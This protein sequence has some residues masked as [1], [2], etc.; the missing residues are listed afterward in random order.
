VE[1]FETPEV[2]ARR[3]RQQVTEERNKAYRNTVTAKAQV[4]SMRKKIAELEQD[5][6]FRRERAAALARSGATEQAQA[7]MAQALLLERQVATLRN[8]L[9]QL[10][11][12]VEELQGALTTLEVQRQAVELQAAHTVARAHTAEAIKA[13]SAA[14]YGDPDSPGESAAELLQRANDRSTMQVALSQA[15]LEVGAALH[16]DSLEDDP[17]LM[18]EARAEVA[19]MA[20]DALGSGNDS[21]PSELPLKSTEVNDET[22]ET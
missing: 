21:G 10:E 14:R 11:A 22:S 20:Q 15:N 18:I 2:L 12:T 3:A 5:A 19:R 16:G 8:D 4:V 9:P 17:T 7:V 1:G 6:L 13:V